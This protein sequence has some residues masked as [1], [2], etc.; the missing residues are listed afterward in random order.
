MFRI[1]KNG[2]TAPKARTPLDETRTGAEGGG[3]SLA[4]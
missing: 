1:N 2:G 3:P 4:F